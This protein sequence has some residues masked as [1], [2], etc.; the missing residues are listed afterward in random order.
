MSL[1]DLPPMECSNPRTY[2]P[3]LKILFKPEYI[4]F[5]KDD[6]PDN[7]FFRETSTIKLCK[8]CIIIQQGDE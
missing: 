1:L 7:I 5:I 2:S 6:F 8:N 3:E 4:S